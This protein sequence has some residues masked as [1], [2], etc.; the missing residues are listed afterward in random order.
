MSRRMVGR[1]GYWIIWARCACVTR[2]VPV[3]L[4]A[5]SVQQ[6]VTADGEDQL[7]FDVRAM[8]VVTNRFCRFFSIRAISSRRGVAYWLDD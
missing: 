3:R 2:L 5:A 6:A 4:E 7:V 1:S 8:V